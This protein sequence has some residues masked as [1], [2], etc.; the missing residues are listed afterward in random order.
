MYKVI[1]S[2]IILFSAVTLNGQK[3]SMGYIYPAG[4]QQGTT[5]E[6]EIGGLNL[7][8]AG[9]VLVSGTGVKATLVKSDEESKEAGN[10]K[11]KLKRK[12]TKLDD[13]SSPQLADRI[14][15]KITIDKN[16]TPG[17][18]DLRL[19][20][21]KSISN[22]LNFEIGQY[23]NVLEINKSTNQHPTVV[24]QLPSTL[25]GQILPGENDYFSFKAEKGITLVASVKARALIPYIADAVPGWFQSVIQIRN[26]KGKEIAYNDDFRNSPDAV[27]I[28][29][30]PETDTYTLVIHDAIYRGREDFTYRIDLGE[31][32]FLEYIYPVAGKINQKTSIHLVGANLAK[33]VILFKPKSEG[34][35][36]LTAIGKNGFASNPVPYVVLPG[37]K[38]YMYNSQKTNELQTGTVIFDSLSSQVHSKSYQI[39]A[40]QNEN[41]VVEVN[42]R[43]L[44]SSLDARLRLYDQKGKLLA[45]SDDV[46]DN[47][48]GLMTFHADPIL[49]YKTKSQGTFRLEME[50]VLANYGKDYFFLLERKN[51][52]PTYEVFVTPANITIPKGGTGTF[53][54]DITTKE[55]VVPAL[56][57][58][59]KGLPAG[60]KVSNLRTLQGMKSFEVS[61]TA[62]DNA[63][64]EK[65][66]LKMVAELKYGSKDRDNSYQTAVPADNMMQA[67]YYMHHIPAAGFVAEIAPEAPFSLHFEPVIENNL[68]NPV[69]FSPNDTV[70]ALKLLIKRKPGFDEP[71]DLALNKKIKQIEL[72]P[73]KLSTTD[74]EKIIHLKIDLNDSKEKNRFI[75]LISIVG[76]VNG[77]VDKRGKRSFQNAKY[78]ETTPLIILKTE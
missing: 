41:I 38:N 24:S 63:K 42:A 1:V 62:P 47:M 72:L 5:V 9:N 52:I 57:F 11:V 77:Q 56:Q 66:D 78:R 68:E 64:E 70:V 35:T 67:F 54:L 73:V 21:A 45:E 34:K 30:I 28:T 29:K 12:Q 65:C 3:M 32:P 13:Q 58:L 60:C 8:D 36:V 26:S 23:P 17:F 14:K 55:K 50:D 49:Q 48:Q 61:V 6:V 76:T 59:L 40:E 19:Q 74:T 18:R 22:K 51:N 71:I 16:A 44:G 27:I 31:I 69:L 37:N 25:C 39:T 7:N 10:Q 75:R 15:V 43:K 20:S 4:G 46:E 53:T 33:N 2:L